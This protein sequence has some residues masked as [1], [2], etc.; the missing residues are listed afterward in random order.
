[1]RKHTIERNI[2]KHL[3]ATTDD[4]VFVGLDVHKRSI[5]V[6]IRINGIL[7]AT[8]VIPASLWAV[9]SILE[10]IRDGI[11]RIVYEAGPTGFGL[12]R[13]LRKEGLPIE[14]VA[15]GKT[16]RPTNQGNKSDRLDC[17]HL[18]EYAEKDLLRP[19]VIP[20]EQQEADRHITR[21]RDQLIKKQR[22]TKQQIKS[23]LL[24]YGIEE[25]AGLSHWTQT[26]LMT[27]RTLKLG[28]QIKM[29]L[30]I[31]L[32]ELEFLLRQ[33]KQVEKYLKELSQTKRHQEAYSRLHTHPGVGD[34]TAMKFVTG[35]YEPH[36]FSTPPQVVSY[37]GLAPGFARVVKHDEKG[38][39]KNRGVERCVRCWLK[40]AG[41]GGI[42]IDGQQRCMRNWCTIPVT[43]KRPLWGL[44]GTWQLTCG[45]C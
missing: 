25:P 43:Q 42:W 32:D 24:Q 40:P 22:R 29:S 31:L 30:E 38:G 36:R 1:M 44:H 17:R 39:Y 41:A 18:A 16:P 28:T 13:A 3:K 21:V 9:I 10:G 27:L 26:A 5:H 20:T 8:F 19:I 37:L 45:A 23:L 12:A 11:R 2:R 15:P 34:I 6:A 14:V 35:G 7:V 4:Q 33:V